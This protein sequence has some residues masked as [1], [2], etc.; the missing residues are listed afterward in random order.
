M[1]ASL[2]LSNLPSPPGASPT[3]G[4]AALPEYRGMHA[5]VNRL[6][7]IVIPFLVLIF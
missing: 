6:M 7:R 4:V 5:N 1:L 3:G 2:L